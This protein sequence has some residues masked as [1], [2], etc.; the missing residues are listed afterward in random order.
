[1]TPS[2]RVRK[3]V[4]PVA[5]LGTRLLPATKVLAKE[6]LPVV[7][8]PLIGQVARGVELV[9]QDDGGLDS[10]TRKRIAEKVLERMESSELYEGKRQPLRHIL[11]CQARHI[12]TF[13]RGERPEYTPFVMG[14]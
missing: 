7:D 6:M 14:W 9:Q 3:A 8:R 12:A 4:F 13:V 2:F 10:A 1:M 5:G 11:Q